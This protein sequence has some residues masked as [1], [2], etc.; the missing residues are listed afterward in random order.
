MQTDLQQAASDYTAIAEAIRY[1]E[2]HQRSQPTLAEIAESVHLSEYHFQRLFTRWVGISP[3]RFL[4]FLTKENAKRLLSE[5]SL[6]DAA[7]QSGLSSAGRLHDLLVQTEAVTP[8]E[9][10]HRGT[11]LKIR[12]G[13]HSS[14][15]NVAFVGF[16]SIPHAPSNNLKQIL[17]MRL[18]YRI[19]PTRRLSS[20]ASSPPPAT[21]RP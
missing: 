3:K 21:E 19:L 4:Q 11:G 16:P 6:L 2:T 18:S 14:P 7:Y 17:E 8:G 20:S 1:I 12:Y 10:K 15:P 9:I 5:S 13:S